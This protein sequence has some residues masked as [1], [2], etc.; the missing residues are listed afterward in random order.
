MKTKKYLL[1]FLYAY[2]IVGFISNLPLLNSYILHRIDGE[3]FKYSNADASYTWHETFDFKSTPI[4][5]RY[6]DRYIAEFR[7]EKKNQQVYRLYH[8]NPLCFWRWSQYLITSKDYD[9]KSWN[10][11]EPNRVPYNLDGRHQDF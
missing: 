7:P 10:E 1:R 9:Y 11:I 8:I 2:L 4:S 5:Q 3:L 6:I